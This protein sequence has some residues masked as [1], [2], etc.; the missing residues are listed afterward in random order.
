MFEEGLRPNPDQIVMDYG[1]VKPEG[2]QI[3]SCAGLADPWHP[4]CQLSTYKDTEPVN[5]IE[6]QDA[7]HCKDM[8]APTDDDSDELKNARASVLSYLTE[9]LS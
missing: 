9:W 6:A 2:N 5:F 8:D 3:V 1:G 4:A 7:S